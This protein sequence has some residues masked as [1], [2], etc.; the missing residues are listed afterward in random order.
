[1]PFKHNAARRRCIPRARYRFT[2]WPAYEVG[3][4]RRGDLTLWLD[5]AALT[6]WA[7]PK[8]SSPGGKPALSTCW[9]EVAMARGK[10]GVPMVM[11]RR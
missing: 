6:G 5:Q 2:N 11:P 10:D 1:M 3:L 7:A 4:R 8:R 9:I